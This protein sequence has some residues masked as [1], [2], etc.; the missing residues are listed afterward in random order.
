MLDAHEAV[1]DDRASGSKDE[2]GRLKSHFRHDVD[3]E[4]GLSIAIDVGLDLMAAGDRCDPQFTGI[5][6]E[7]VRTDPGE[8]VVGRRQGI[9]IDRVQVDRVLAPDEVADGIAA[10][11][12]DR[13][14]LSFSNRNVS[15]PAPP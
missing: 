11:P 7:G 14:S 2:I 8:G 13:L 15:W 9:G 5:L 1:V 4:I 12:V 3:R 6:R 10:R